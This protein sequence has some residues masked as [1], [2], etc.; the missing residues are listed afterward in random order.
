M[1][2]FP[3]PSP[4]APSGNAP[5]VPQGAPSSGGNPL[6]MLAS[7]GGDSGSLLQVILTFLAGMGGGTLLEHLQKLIKGGG[8]GG[9]P[10]PG[11]P[12]QPGQPSPGGGM[13][14]G[15]TPQMLAQLAQRG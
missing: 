4:G 14:P 8:R 1:A 3:S 2:A 11:Q 13:P 10:K 15:M 12:G 7:K 9:P 6:E 5:P